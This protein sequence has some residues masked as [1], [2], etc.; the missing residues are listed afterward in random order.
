ML[1]VS[2]APLVSHP[3]NPCQ[4]LQQPQQIGIK[5]TSK[6]RQKDAKDILK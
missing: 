5:L 3:R 2:A 1:S 4:S 6:T